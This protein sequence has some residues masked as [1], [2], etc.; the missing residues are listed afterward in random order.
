ML[1]LSIHPVLKASDLERLYPGQTRHQMNRRWTDGSSDGTCTNS[2]A[3][4][5]IRRIY[6]LDYWFIW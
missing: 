5:I 2:S 3:S 1:E 6:K 4:K